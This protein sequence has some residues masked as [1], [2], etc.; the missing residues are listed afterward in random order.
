MASQ[1]QRVQAILSSTDPASPLYYSSS[2]TAVL[3]MDYHNFIIGMIQTPEAKQGV[4]SNVKSLLTW[5]RENGVLVVHALIDVTGSPAENTKAKARWPK[6]KQILEQNPVA[7]DEYHEFAS[8]EEVNLT[9]RPGFTSALESDNLRPLLKERGI[10]SL[11]MAGLSTSGC[12]LSTA[13]AAPDQGYVSTVVED[14]C[15]DSFEGLHDRI[16]EQILPV[17]TNVVDTKTWI[18]EAGKLK[19]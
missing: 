11:V 4:I 9:R 16:V 12:T 18:E 8:K 15:W 2:Q 14:C 5:A 10:K 7:G 13:R 17:N 6:Y 19:Q 3:L 1:P